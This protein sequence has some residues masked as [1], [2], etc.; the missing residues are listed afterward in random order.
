M[1]IYIQ[2]G[3]V[4]LYLDSA[5]HVSG[6]IS[7][8]NQKRTELYLQHLAL[9]KSYCLPA[10]TVDELERISNSSTSSVHRKH[11]PIY[12]QEDATLH[13]LISCFQPNALVYY[14]FSSNYL[15]TE[16]SHKK[17]DT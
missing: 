8:H 16:R 9:V 2:Q 3:A 6:G 11:I 10:A 15:C 4:Y 7:T 1:Y 12:I 14:I 13:S 17:S 5:L